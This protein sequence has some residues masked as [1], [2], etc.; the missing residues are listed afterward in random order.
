VPLAPAAIALLK[1]LYT[2]D[3]NDFIFLGY[4]SDGLSDAAMSGLLERMGKTDITV[5]GFRSTFRDWCA[6]TTA[7][8]ADVVEM[9]LAHTIQNKTEAA[10][11]RTDLLAKR[12][13]LME[14]WAKFCSRKPAV[15]GKVLPMRGRR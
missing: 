6:E 11:K 9:A 3:G 4:R 1:S 15:D 10:Y 5:H 12:G 13:K 7:F 8:P 14:A 2:E